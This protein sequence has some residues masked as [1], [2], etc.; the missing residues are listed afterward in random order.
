MHID[1]KLSQTKRVTIVHGQELLLNDAYPKYFR[2]NVATA[3]HKR[4]VEV[5]LNDWVDS[6]DIIDPGLI[7]TRSGRKLV[8]D[9]V[10]SLNNSNVS[11][12]LSIHNF[13]Q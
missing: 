1:Q 2:K 10:V 5:I 9:L 8:A 4:G 13:V 12:S 7:S 11:I 3:I 6:L